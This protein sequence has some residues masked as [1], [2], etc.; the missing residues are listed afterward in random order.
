VSSDAEAFLSPDGSKLFFASKRSA[1]GT[2]A[3]YDMWFV[4]RRGAEWGE[5]RPVAAINS[6]LQELYPSVSDDGTLYFSRSGPAGSDLW[7]SRWTE[8]GYASPEHLP[9]PINTDHREAGVFVSP[10]HSFIMFESNRPGGLGRTDLYISY[11][12][13]GR[14]TEPKNLGASFNS[15][16]NETSAILSRDG[17]T[18]Y[19]TSDRRSATAPSIGRGLS[20]SRILN[21]LQQ[22]GNGRWHIYHAPFDLAGTR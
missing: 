20:Y 19:F 8:Q 12:R 22:P 3:D 21:Q 10:D 11:R 6:E 9:S 17:R 15:P 16:S 2:K 14:W 18:I 5:P 13:D 7:R 1:S 4:E